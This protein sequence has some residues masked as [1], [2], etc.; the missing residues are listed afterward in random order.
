[1]MNTEEFMVFLVERKANELPPEAL[2]EVFD[3]LIWCMD[4][5]GIEISA[6]QRKWL[7]SQ[8]R[9]LVQVAL[10]MK[11]ACP[12]Q[13]L[14]DLFES[15]EKATNNFPDLRFSI[16]GFKEMWVAMGLKSC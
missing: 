7:V 6:V 15:L 11:D 14:G 13:T 1:M 10:H 16:N 4:D 9:Y 8:E 2:A 5:N 3:K 12:F